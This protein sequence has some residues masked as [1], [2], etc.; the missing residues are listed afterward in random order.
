MAL[1]K[2]SEQAPAAHTPGPWRYAPAIERRF[3]SSTGAEQASW[4]YHWVVNEA[5]ERVACGLEGLDATDSPNARLTAAAPELLCACEQAIK[6]LKELDKYR[7]VDS[8]ATCG[9]IERAIA[10]A[11]GG[12]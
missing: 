2:I 10:K 11:K 3:C 7:E 4:H 6:R 5:G 8:S 1:K 12:V 9:L